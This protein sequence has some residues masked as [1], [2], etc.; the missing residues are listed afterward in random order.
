MYMLEMHM[1]MGLGIHYLNTIERPKG[2]L[3]HSY[4]PVNSMDGARKSRI[5]GNPMPF[6]LDS[7]SS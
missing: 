7:G 3:P 6:I 1:R 4:Q 2:Q 5:E